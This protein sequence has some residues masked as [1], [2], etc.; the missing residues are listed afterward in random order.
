MAQTVKNLLTHGQRG[1]N[2]WAWQIPWRRQWLPT[3]VFL[4]EEF[5]GQRSLVG[6]SPR[7]CKES[8]MSERTRTQD[9]LTVMQ[10]PEAQWG[11]HSLS[12]TDQLMSLR[13]LL[14]TSVSPFLIC[15]AEMI[16]LRCKTFLMWTILSLY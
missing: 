10:P 8:D 11:S 3:P 5:Y 7:G 9:H 6:Y 12:A 1:F 14:E 4:P 15:T 2:P 13:D 16:I